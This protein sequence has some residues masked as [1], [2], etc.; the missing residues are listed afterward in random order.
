MAKCS[1]GMTAVHRSELW[2]SH[3]RNER[4]VIAHEQQVGMVSVVK[5]H[6]MV[7]T[8]GCFE[9]NGRVETVGWGEKHGWVDTCHYV[10]L[11]M[12]LRNRN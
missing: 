10:Q 3:L 8:A 4:M 6:C 11:Q 9:T 5:V 2:F 12:I 7:E 1:D